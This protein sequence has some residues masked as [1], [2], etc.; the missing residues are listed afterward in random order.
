MRWTVA[1]LAQKFGLEAAGDAD[2]VIDGVCALQ[3]GR[4]GALTFLADPRYAAQ[5]ETTT[6]AAVLLSARDRSRFAGP[7][8]IAKDPALAFARVA[9]LFDSSREFTAGVHAAATVAAGARLGAGVGI[10]P[11]A[12]VEEGVE[13]GDGSWIGPGCVIRRDARIGAHS[14]LEANIYVGERCELGSRTSVLAGAVIGSRGFGLARAPDGWIEVPQ[15]GKVVIGDDVEIGANTCID[16]GALDDTVIENGV[17]LDN[18]VQIAHNC[19]IGAHTAIAACVGMAGSTTIGQRC[20]IAGACGIGGH[21]KIA[22]DVVILGFTMVT[23]SLT[24]PG[25]YGSGL[26]VLPARDWRKQVARVHRLKRLEERIEQ[27][28]AALQLKSA[29]GKQEGEEEHG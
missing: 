26:P 18:M 20:M 12:V 11:H 13:I 8:L 19:R 5:L 6:A 25:V 17:K 21:L 1:Q 23:K 2:T 27:V 4:A 14:R 15:L 7:A 10:G 22:D 29:H 16:R 24:K 9:E 28:E 3:P